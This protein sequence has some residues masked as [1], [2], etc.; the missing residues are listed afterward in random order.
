M[1]FFPKRC[2]EGRYVLRHL[3]LHAQISFIFFTRSSNNDVNIKT[4]PSLVGSKSISPSLIIPSITSVQIFIEV[5]EKSK[6]LG[7]EILHLCTIILYKY[8][9]QFLASFSLGIIWKVSP[10]KRR[11]NP[12][13]KFQQRFRTLNEQLNSG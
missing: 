9:L 6:I 4:F 2:I 3:F 5:K 1:T 10:Q 11:R 12:W 7:V 8:T 13:S